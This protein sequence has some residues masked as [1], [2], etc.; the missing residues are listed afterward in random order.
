MGDTALQLLCP[1]FPVGMQQFTE[2]RVVEDMFMGESS[3][4]RTIMEGSP[5]KWYAI[6]GKEHIPAGIL[7]LQPV[8]GFW[9]S[10]TFLP[11]SKHHYMENA[12]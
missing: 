11:A 1:I 2:Y 9:P 3:V 4:S 12:S 7:V 6:M 10:H 8:R 5:E